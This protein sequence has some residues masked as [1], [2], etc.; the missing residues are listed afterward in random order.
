[1]F[2]EASLPEHLCIGLRVAVAGACAGAQSDLREKERRSL[3]EHRGT[4]GKTRRRPTEETAENGVKYTCRTLKTLEDS[5]F[6]E[7]ELHRA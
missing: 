4:E 2:H 3:E 7:R 1:M 6:E 5:T